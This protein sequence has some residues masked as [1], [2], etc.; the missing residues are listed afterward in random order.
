MKF[1][2]IF[3]SLIILSSKT[4]I[5][6]QENFKTED[7]NKFSINQLPDVDV[8]KIDVSIDT[9]TNLGNCPYPN[10]GLNKGNDIVP[11]ISDEKRKESIIKLI[12][13]I[14]NCEKLPFKQD[15]QIFYNKEGLLPQMPKGYYRE[16]TLVIPKDAQKEFYIGNT[17]YTAYPSYGTRGPERIVIGGGQDIYYS[18]THYDSFIKI[19][20]VNTK[21]NNC[22]CG[23]DN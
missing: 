19:I 17:L 2:L 18:P 5:F 1:L 22:K 4:S 12:E 8:S 21:Q 10:G 7:F 14:I 16:Y 23:L 3:L 13:K 11:F 6:T 9:S 15:G 20:I